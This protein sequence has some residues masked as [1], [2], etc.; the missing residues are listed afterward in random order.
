MHL[1]S[2]EGRLAYAEQTTY[3]DRYVPDTDDSA[4]TTTTGTYTCEL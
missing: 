3:V 2:I 4:Q 1:E